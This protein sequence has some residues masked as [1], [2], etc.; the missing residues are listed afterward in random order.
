MN[1]ISRRAGVGQGSLYRHFPN[2]ESVALAV[3]GEN[4]AELEELA[5]AP[6]ATLAAVLAVIVDQ[7]IA[8]IAFIVMLDPADAADPRLAEVS[9]R[10]RRLLAD[11]LA[12]AG[13]AGTIRR[14][15]TIEDLVLVMSMLSGLLRATDAAAR[16]AAGRR[17]WQL[18]WRG[19]GR[20]PGAEDQN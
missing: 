11:K 9:G 1:L 3:F 17:A 4:I 20:V 5:A 15:I 2:R 10:V 12:Q 18:L 8:S 13:A 7:L 16:P 14:D 6:D 19:M